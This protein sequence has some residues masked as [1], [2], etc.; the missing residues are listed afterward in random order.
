MD[1]G[2][3]EHTKQVHEG[4]VG[5]VAA[6]WTKLTDL[7][8]WEG[9][10]RINAQAVPK[11]A[12]SIQEFGFGAPVVAQKG[13]GL[14]IA[15]HTRIEAARLLG[16]SAVPVRFIDITDAKAKALALADN[17]LGELADWD[18]AKLA[19]VI[20]ALQDE[21]VALL[22]AAGFDDRELV[23][24]LSEKGD[25]I[26]AE[27]WVGMPE[28]VS[29]DQTAWGSV[30][31]NFANEKDREAFATLVGQTITDQT[32]SIWYPPAEIGRY[33]DKE[34]AESETPDLHRL[35]G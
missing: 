14:V 2:A 24:I 21:D 32:R 13:T 23:R 10:P 34:Y 15:G 4:A 22:E 33:A 30:K 9:N 18:D 6:V 26:A 8:G 27:E 5:E 31:V 7:V 16:M 12:E 11:V 29:E 19:D 35:E 1:S 28:C 17:K 20:R 3:A 25:N